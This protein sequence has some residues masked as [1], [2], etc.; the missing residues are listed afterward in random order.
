MLCGMLHAAGCLESF[1]G[2][3]Y[4]IG[5]IAVLQEVRGSIPGRVVVAVVVTVMSYET[6]IA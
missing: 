1:C 6:K 5:V 4:N 3:S 2:G